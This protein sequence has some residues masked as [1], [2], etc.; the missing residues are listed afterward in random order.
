VP[1]RTHHNSLPA[2]LP[3]ATPAE[4]WAVEH[5]IPHQINS[6]NQIGVVQNQ[7]GCQKIGYQQNHKNPQFM[8]AQILKS[9]NYKKN[10]K[11][12]NPKSSMAATGSSSLVCR[13]SS[14]NSR[15][16]E[17]YQAE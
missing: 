3:R 11:S 13:H 7:I 14:P 2:P 12:T 8:D 17:L 10:P 15:V 16:E 4:S 9:P 5:S 1:S 6:S